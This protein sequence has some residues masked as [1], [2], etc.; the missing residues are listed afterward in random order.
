MLTT[1]S[2]V[3]RFQTLLHGQ[4]L[5]TASSSQKIHGIADKEKLHL[6]QVI[7]GIG[8]AAML[9]RVSFCYLEG[10]AMLVQEY[11]FKYYVKAECGPRGEVHRLQS[12]SR[13]GATALK[14]QRSTAPSQAHQNV[15]R[16]TQW[17]DSLH[18][19]LFI[20]G[21]LDC[22]AA[23]RPFPSKAHIETSRRETGYGWPSQ[24]ATTFGS[25]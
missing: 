20:H 3:I 21:Y 13:E 2:S 4:R 12:S 9:V 14:A 25:A 23:A 6:P 5:T 10:R 11:L 24:V 7:V 8:K 1:A 19:Q 22:T 16:H 17:E 18:N 15:A